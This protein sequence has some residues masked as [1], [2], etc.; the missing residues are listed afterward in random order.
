MGGERGFEAALAF[1]TCEAVESELDG[2]SKK[3]HI[4]I[5]SAIP[6]TIVIGLDRRNDRTG[7]MA[8]CTVG[9]PQSSMG[10]RGRGIACAE[11]EGTG[12]VVRSSS[13]RYGRLCSLPQEGG[14]DDCA[15]EVVDVGYFL[16]FEV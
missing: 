10:V 2:E 14:F 1:R 5:T 8:I 13:R 3:T 6:T 15:G 4:I 7:P 11:A 12:R 9:C 16:R